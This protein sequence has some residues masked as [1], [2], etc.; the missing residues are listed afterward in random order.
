MCIGSRT[1]GAREASAKKK[2]GGGQGRPGKEWRELGVDGC[3]EGADQRRQGN[4]WK[5][6]GRGE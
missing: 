4:D 3:K 6:L 1:A 2:G 5:Q